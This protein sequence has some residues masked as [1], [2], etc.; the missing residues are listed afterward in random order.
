L[1]ESVGSVAHVAV[2]PDPHIIW[3]VRHVSAQ[4]P[5]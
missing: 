5:L 3:P 1:A 4:I 2:A